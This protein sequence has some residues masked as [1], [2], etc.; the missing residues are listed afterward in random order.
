MDSKKGFRANIFNLTTAAMLLAAAQ[1]LPLLTGH[2]PQIGRM[3][4]P[5][6]IPILLCGF[7]CGPLWGGI[8]GFTAPFLKYIT[9]GVPVLFPIGIAM[10]FELAAY[11]IIAG[12]HIPMIS[13]KESKITGKYII[14]LYIAL[15]DS[16]L[17]GRIVYGIAMFIMMAAGKNSYSFTA[18]LTESF[19]EALPGI[20]LQLAVIPPLFIAVSALRRYE[21]KKR[22]FSE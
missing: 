10:A 21:L 17:C 3:L 1:L 14:N 15:I 13:R 19:A 20:I 5:M 7:I 6:H 16:M 22:S 12:L 2:I 18:F 9:A 4:C 8:I 11:G